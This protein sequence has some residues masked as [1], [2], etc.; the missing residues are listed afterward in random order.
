MER[1]VLVETTPPSTAMA[2]TEEGVS[3][4][5]DCEEDGWR[6]GVE[7]FELDV[8]CGRTRL[9]WRKEKNAV[10][11]VMISRGFDSLC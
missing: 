6:R 10:N 1:W 4:G 9:A 5:R 2:E 11:R 3:G 8:E 7:V